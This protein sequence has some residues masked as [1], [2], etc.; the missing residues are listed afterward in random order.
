MLCVFSVSELTSEIKD[1]LETQFA[2][3]WV[4]GE[5]SEVSRPQSGHIYFTLKDESSQ[6]R[7]VLWRSAAQRLPFTLEDGQQVIVQAMSTS[8]CPAAV[9]R[10][11]F[12]PSSRKG[13]VRCRLLSARCSSGWPRKGCLILGIRSRCRRFLSES[14]L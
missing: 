13:L 14:P 8:I 4:S 9:I 7:A 10:S 11:S 12:A 3:I 1:S 5:V 2:S 6:I